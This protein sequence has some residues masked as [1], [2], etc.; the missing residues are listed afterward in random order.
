ML[1]L[2]SPRG[3]RLASALI[4]LFVWLPSIGHSE[5]NAGSDQAATSRPA[6]AP[7]VRSDDTKLK[8][9]KGDFVA[10]PIPISNPTF[11]TGLVACAARLPWS[12]GGAPA[13]GAIDPGLGASS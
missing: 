9:Q 6:R 8:L 1:L 3:A 13:V 4:V 11:D 7:D 5:S 2:V 10:V 12:A